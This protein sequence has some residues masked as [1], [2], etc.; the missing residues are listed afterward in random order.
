MTIDTDIIA[1]WEQTKWITLSSMFFIIP[2]TYAFFNNI[3][4][5]SS[6]LFITSAV[7]A[8]YW[9][10]A[11][12]SWRRDLDFTVAKIS[13]ITGVSTGIMYL[14]SPFY[15][16]IFAAGLAGLS[17]CY[18]LSNHLHAIKNP[19]WWKYHVAFHALLTCEQFLVFHNMIMSRQIPQNRI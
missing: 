14:R 3:Y 2:A 13:V 6:L 18:Y 4:Y 8:N 16:T 1:P 19:N 11:K 5:H 12:P 9:R 17:Y 15:L 10:E 7:S